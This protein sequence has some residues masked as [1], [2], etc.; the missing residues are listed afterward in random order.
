M[1]EEK[2]IP[3][4]TKDENG[5]WM[6]VPAFDDWDMKQGVLDYSMDFL[7]IREARKINKFD[8]SRASLGNV[9]ELISIECNT[10]D[11]H[12]VPAHNHE[13]HHSPTTRRRIMSYFNCC[14]RA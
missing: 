10:A 1:E 6:S 11:V 14:I 5:G 13:E 3:A 2:E 8:L 4:G 7:K 9:E 12:R